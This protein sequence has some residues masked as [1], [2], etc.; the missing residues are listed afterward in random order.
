MCFL[1]NAPRLPKSVASGGFQASPVSPSGN[2]Y[3]WMK[4][5][6][7]ISEIVLTGEIEV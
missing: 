7:S 1:Y 2:S 6:W 3:M 5:N 4:M